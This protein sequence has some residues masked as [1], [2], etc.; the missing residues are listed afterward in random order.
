MDL[1]TRAE[2]EADKARMLPEFQNLSLPG[3]KAKVAE[4]LGLFGRIEGLFSTYTVHDITHIDAMLKMLDWVVP[5][6]TQKVMSPLDWLITVLAIYFHDMGMVV[7]AEEY[8]HR[9]TKSEFVTWLDGLNK[10]T[11]GREYLARTNRMTPTE[12][13][14]FFFQ[15]FVR[16]GHA[17]RIREF[18]TGRRSRI[19]GNEVEPLAIQIAEMLKP[20]PSRFR[21]YLGMVCESHHLSNLHDTNIYPLCARCGNDPSEIVNVQYSAILLRTSDLLH[22]TKDRTPSVM[23]EA[24]HFSDPKSVGEWDKQLGAFAVGPKG[25]QLDEENIESAVI[26]INADFTEERPL[27]SLQEYIAYANGEMQQSKR[28]ADVSKEQPDGKG[29]SFPWHTVRGDVRLEGV[30]PQPLRFD[31]DRGRLLDLLVGH[32]I[33]NDPTVA[34]RELLQNSVD[35]VRYQYYLATREARTNSS[36]TPAMGKVTVKWDSTDRMLTVEDDGIGMDRDIITFHLMKVGSSYYST[37]Q[38]EAEHRDFTPIS[39]FGIGILTCFMVSDDIEI[40]TFRGD[41]G[42]RIRMTSVQADYLLRELLPGDPKLAGLEPHGTRVTLR[43]RGTVDVSERSVEK[44]VR[45]WVILPECCVEYVEPNKSPVEIGFDSPVHALREFHSD[46]PRS[47]PD[48]FYKLEFVVKNRR[49]IDLTEDVTESGQYE[50]AV[51]VRSSILPERLFAS[52]PEVDLPMVCIEGIRVSNRLPWF[53]GERGNEPSALLSVRGARRFRTTVS[54]TGLEEDEEY[55]RV[56]QICVDMLFEHVRDEVSAIAGKS[57]KPLSQASTASKFLSDALSQA[58]ASRQAVE[59][60]N[61]LR[62]Q[63][64]SVVVEHVEGAWEKPVTRRSLVTPLELKGMPQFWTV[65]SRLVDSLGTMSRALDRELSLNEFLVALAPDFKELRYSPLLPDAHF[66]VDDFFGSHRPGK[67]EFSVK[68]QQT[69]VMWVPRADPSDGAN[70]NL[71]KL[72]SAKFLRMVL[73]FM[74]QTDVDYVFRYE[75][76]NLDIRVESAEI[77]GDRDGV[78][79]I[80]S[81]V[82]IIFKT[83]NQLDAIWSSLRQPLMKYASA[84]RD[85]RAVARI[86]ALAHVYVKAVQGRGTNRREIS[87]V[88][89]NLLLQTK[90]NLKEANI[91]ADLPSDIYEVVTEMSV[92][93]ASSYWRN[94]YKDDS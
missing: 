19:W 46:D 33:Y 25:R 26:V 18:I 39:R 63:L 59:Y 12:R 53:T 17:A 38:F 66:F 69:A 32:T 58:T 48:S 2:L 75:R 77:V 14:R 87:T 76:P 74:R 10:T 5:P 51:A 24:I 82:G 40:V 67:V 13:D 28:W 23:Y 55:E 91:T 37:P 3:V 80:R 65:E 34:I 61:S 72:C 62:G 6:S 8:E 88:W 16:K 35:A 9:E 22:V 7:T 90:E 47:Q 93:D 11:E 83:G 64:A 57:G 30:P 43:L 85:A 78:E 44:I 15:E 20:L 56:G 36:S 70:V 31:L 52:K 92:F 60:L 4:I 94:W 41:K 79:A 71:D 21:D 86:L 84:E 89:K 27:F 29:Y 54:R 81:R 50:L 73:D 42:H 49:P 68:H 45:H 1:H